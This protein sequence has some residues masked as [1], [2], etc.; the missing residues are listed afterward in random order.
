MG[1][2]SSQA[3]TMHVVA[4]EL[5]KMR[6]PLRSPSGPQ[7]RWVI[8]TLIRAI[9]FPWPTDVAYWGTTIDGNP[10]ITPYRNKSQAWRNYSLTSKRC[11]RGL[12]PVDEQGGLDRLRVVDERHRLA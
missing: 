9:T 1:P 11:R 7:E 4:Q 3:V 8:Q 12:F 2:K 10:R 5:K 6:R